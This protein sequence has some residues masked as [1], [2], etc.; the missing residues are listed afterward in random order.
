MAKACDDQG[1]VCQDTDPMTNDCQTCATTEG[2]CGDEFA[3]CGSFK[4]PMHPCVKLNQCNSGCQ[5]LPM[6]E[7]QA[8]VMKC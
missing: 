8:C 6:A 1:L 5:M 3:A 7:Q 2:S 4:D